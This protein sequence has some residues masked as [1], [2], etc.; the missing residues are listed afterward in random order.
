MEPFV[1]NGET[2]ILERTDDARNGE[3]VIANINGDIY[4]KRIKKDP[5]N[6]W[7]KFLSDNN[8]YDEIELKGKDLEHV[9]II[10]I[11]RAKIR[12]F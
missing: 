11:V 12:P 7:V 4:I 10:G 5:L 9:T 2:V 6:R 1:S 3:T 8:E